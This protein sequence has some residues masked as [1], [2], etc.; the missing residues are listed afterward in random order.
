MIP[1]SRPSI[2]GTIAMTKLHDLHDNGQS[3]WLDFIRRDM[4]ESG[5]LAGL[6]ADGVRGLTSNPTIFQQAISTSTAY[7][8]QIADVIQHSPAAGTG[9]VFEELAVADIRD[10]ADAL[11]GVY[12]ESDGADGFVSLEVSPHLAHDTDGTV[13][14]ARRLWDW[15]DRPNLMIKVPGTPAGIPAQ[16]ELLAA[17]MN[18]N[19]TLMFSLA[20]YEAVAHAHLRGLSRADNPRRIASVASFFVSRVDSKTDAALEKIGSREAMDLRGKIA[21]ANAKLAYRRFQELYQGEA[22]AQLAS[23]GARPQRVLWAST[24]TKNPEYRDVLY[25]E[26][27]IGPDTVNTMP[28][29]TIEAFSDHG[30]I[31]ANALTG[32]VDDAA[33]QIAA[34]DRLGIDFDEIT[35]ELQ[36]EGVVAFADSFDDLLSALEVKIGELRR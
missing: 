15:V 28:P 27:L 1:T 20:D 33:D 21:V 36:R 13:A 19:S 22:F 23:A 32:G 34:L 10:A 16:E 30:I 8:E 6:V 25:V 7:D 14:D 17:G 35:A 29:A 12:Q 5:E 2:E 24:S 11:Q 26:D 18:I 31:D 9:V 4:L 3:V